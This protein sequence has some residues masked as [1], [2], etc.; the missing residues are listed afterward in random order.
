MW[1]R[2]TIKLCIIGRKLRD[3]K[4]IGQLSMYEGLS[5]Q[6]NTS[7]EVEVSLKMLQFVRAFIVLLQLQALV[8]QSQDF[9]DL[10][11]IFVNG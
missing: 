7:V 1:M 5:E 9:K 2:L 11:F 8:G 3:K 10:K 6:F 4:F